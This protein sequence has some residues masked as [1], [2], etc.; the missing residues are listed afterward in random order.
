[1][2]MVAEKAGLRVLQPQSVRE[3]SFQRQLEAL[4]PDLIV[5]VAFGQKIPPEI[6]EL[7]LTAA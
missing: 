2:K 3:E 4:A 7:P 6:L 1:M 5:V